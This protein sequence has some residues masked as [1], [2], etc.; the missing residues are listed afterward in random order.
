MRPSGC[1][2][3]THPYGVGGDVIVSVDGVQ[4][5]ERDSIQAIAAR[6]RPG[7]VIPVQLWRDGRLM[8]VRVTLAAAP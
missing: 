5:T 1:S 4:L 7:D 8:T 2:T 3:A 6:H